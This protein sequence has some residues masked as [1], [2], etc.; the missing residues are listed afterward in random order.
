MAS[1]LPGKTAGK[2][3]EAGAQINADKF[4]ASKGKEG[5]GDSKSIIGRMVQNQSHYGYVAGK[6]IKDKLFG[7]GASGAVD[8][9]PNDGGGK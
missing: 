2:V 3:D 7:G 4:K 5:Y 1:A 6:K 9:K 8:V